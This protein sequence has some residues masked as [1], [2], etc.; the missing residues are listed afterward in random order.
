[1]DGRPHFLLMNFDS[2]L[3]ISE[4]IC[5]YPVT[6]IPESIP[7][8]AARIALA[9]ARVKRA[10]RITRIDLDYRYIQ[11]SLWNI[12]KQ[13]LILQSHTL[14]YLHPNKVVLRSNFLPELPAISDKARLFC[15]QSQCLRP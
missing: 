1:M 15:G 2:P 9:R 14:H 13:G 3:S 7:S 8:A 6:G 10:N 5:A 4:I 12:S 11:L